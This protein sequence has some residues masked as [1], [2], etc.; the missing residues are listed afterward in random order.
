[1]MLAEEILSFSREDLIGFLYDC[2]NR[3]AT[4]DALTEICE[5]LKLLKASGSGIRPHPPGVPVLRDVEGSEMLKKIKFQ[6][7]PADAVS[8]HL[9]VAVN[10][11]TVIDKDYKPT[12]LESE[13]F[14][15]DNSVAAVSVTG[16][17]TCADAAGNVSVVTPFA[18]SVPPVAPPDTTP[19]D[20]AAVPTLEDA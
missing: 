2:C 6:G 13:P 3:R 8:Q 11:T 14:D 1:M 17:V 16:T 15:V 9:V 12:D 5:E 19:P 7:L 10:G 18:F 20:A 4:A